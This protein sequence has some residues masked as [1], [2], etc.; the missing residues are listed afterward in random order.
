MFTIEQKVIILE[1]GKPSVGEL[2]LGIEPLLCTDG[3]V[4]IEPSTTKGWH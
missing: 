3:N 1:G 2:E 4:S